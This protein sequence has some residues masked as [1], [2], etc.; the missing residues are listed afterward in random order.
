MHRNSNRW[1]LPAAFAMAV[2]ATQAQDPP[3]AVSPSDP[4][5]TS[6]TVPPLVYRS[7]LTTY[8]RLGDDKPVPWR[9][10]NDNVARIGGWRAYAREASEPA[11]TER[12]GPAATSP[13]LPAS[14]PSTPSAMPMPAGHGGHKMH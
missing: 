13:P 6:A 10:A 1:L 11:S 7:T 14:P 12:G 8:R 9:Q 3:R 5:E 4:L 2:S